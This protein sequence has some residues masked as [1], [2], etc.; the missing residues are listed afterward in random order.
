MGDASTAQVSSCGSGDP[1]M[2]TVKVLLVCTGGIKNDGITSWAIQT[3]GAMDRTGL[4]LTAVAW[5]DSPRDA[6]ERVECAGLKVV[7]LPNRKSHLREYLCSFDELLEHGFDVVHACG[8][9]SFLGLE[10]LLAKR[11]G[12]GMRIAHSH[13]TVCSHCVADRV[14]R[15]LLYNAATDLYACGVDAGKWLFGNRGF[16]VIPNGKDP[17][18]FRFDSVKRLKVRK[19]LDISDDVIAIGHVGRIN[20]QKN[21]SFLLDVFKSF[22]IN[23]REARLF[24]IG[25]DGGLMSDVRNRVVE[26]GLQGKVLFLGRRTDVSELL[27]GMDCMV[28][29][30][31]YEGFPNVVLEWQYNGLPCVISDVI[32]DECAVTPLVDRMSLRKSPN[33]W[34]AVVERKLLDSDRANDSIRASETLRVAGYDVNENAKMLKRLYIE[35]VE[36][37]K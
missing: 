31:L 16:T 27:N 15:P 24:L 36:R 34:A 5:E 17:V 30:S 26:L 8:S 33:D 4:D 23:N 1:R 20:E 7:Q 35:G 32:T 12:T 9:S 2:S 29:P 28:F 11:A 37:N 13:N 14:L 3:Y 10:L 25:D 6:V 22:L 19:M 18:S 21:Q